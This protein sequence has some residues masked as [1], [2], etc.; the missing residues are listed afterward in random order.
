MRRDTPT[1]MIVVNFGMWGDIVD[2][3]THAKF[4]VNRFRGW[5]FCDTPKSALLYRLN[6]S[7]LQQ[8]IVKVLELRLQTCNARNQDSVRLIIPEISHFEDADI[9]V[10]AWLQESR[11]TPTPYAF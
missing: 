3:I 10:A 8:C 5:G 6:W 1:W 9:A 2:I 7:L 4:Y 11:A